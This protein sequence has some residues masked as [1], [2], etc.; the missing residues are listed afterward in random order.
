MTRVN[1]AA[2]ICRRHE[3]R[4]TRLALL[5][6]KPIAANCYTFGGLDYLSDKF[7]RVLQDGGVGR[8]DSVA[9]ALPQSAALV[10]A[11]LG[12]LKLGAAVIVLSHDAD[13]GLAEVAVRQRGAKAIVAPF[14]LREAYLSVANRTTGVGRL[15][16]AG[17][18]STAIHYDGAGKS[19]WRDLYLSSSDFTAAIPVPDSPQ[20]I[21]C[22][23]TPTGTVDCVAIDYQAA[24]DR[25]ENGWL[26]RDQ[27]LGEGSVL[28]CGDDWSTLDLLLGL[29]YPAFWRG[30]SV[31]TKDPYGLSAEGALQFFG[32][33]DVSVAFLASDLLRALLLRATERSVPDLMLRKVVVRSSTFTPDTEA[34]V[35]QRLGVGSHLLP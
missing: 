15:F 17:D 23:G 19:F 32:E 11:Q 2:A 1:L 35:R 33:Y 3:D 21:F 30:F 26:S 29:V 5:D 12:V 8:S 25:M 13:L 14:D 9:I 7:A 24:L 34:L 18:T 28:W 27:D 4:I 16:L 31:V 6:A 22:S 20:F 10:T